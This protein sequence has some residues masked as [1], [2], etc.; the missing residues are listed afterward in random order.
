MPTISNIQEKSNT[1]DDS[2]STTVVRVRLINMKKESLNGAIGTRRTWN[3]KKN[4]RFFM[5]SSQLLLRF[6]SLSH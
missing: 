1:V 3:E 2:N 4:I 5:A 6:K